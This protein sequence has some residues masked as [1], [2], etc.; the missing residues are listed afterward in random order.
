MFIIFFFTENLTTTSDK[1]YETPQIELNYHCLL[2]NEHFAT[3]LILNNHIKESKK[4]LKLDGY[5]I[6]NINSAIKKTRI[7]EQ[8]A[9]QSIERYDEMLEAAEKVKE[10]ATFYGNIPDNFVQKIQTLV[11]NKYVGKKQFLK[12]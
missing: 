2:C 11:L 8:N 5:R 3:Q 12:L 10:K 4:H 1:T 6:E 9:L 7:L